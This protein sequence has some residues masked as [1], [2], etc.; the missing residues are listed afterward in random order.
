LLT[1]SATTSRSSAEKSSRAVA[2][3]QIYTRHTAQRGS[4][5]AIPHHLPPVSYKSTQLHDAHEDDPALRKC[6]AILEG[7][8]PEGSRLI[9]AQRSWT[10]HGSP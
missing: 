7:R 1:W 10:Q 5:A 9:P 6:N 8:Q 3:L 2:A 4:A